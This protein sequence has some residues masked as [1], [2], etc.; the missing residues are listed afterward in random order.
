MPR[1]CMHG[2]HL[3][4][5]LANVREFNICQE[6]VRE[7]YLLL[8][9]S[10]GLCQCLVDCCMPSYTGIVCFEELPLTKSF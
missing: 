9:S 2:D 5:K 7:N 10:L 4:G 3:P 8:I 1:Y 6:I